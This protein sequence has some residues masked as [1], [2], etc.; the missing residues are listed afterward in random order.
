M[1]VEI[2]NDKLVEILK[3]REEIHKEIGGYMEELMAIDEKKKKA[4][5]KMEKLKEKTKVIMDKM[6]IET[7]EFHIVSRVFMEDGK[8]Y[9]E[10]IDLVEEYKQALREKAKESENE[11]SDNK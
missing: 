5:Y 8:A 10:V 6:N 9:Y 7:E 11:D 1:K 4:G 2:Q 3:Q